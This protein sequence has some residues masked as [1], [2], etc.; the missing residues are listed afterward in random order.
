[1]HLNLNVLTKLND[2]LFFR[3]NLIGQHNVAH[4]CEVG[5][6]RINGF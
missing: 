2:L 3:F 5:G 1:M 6:K 4:N